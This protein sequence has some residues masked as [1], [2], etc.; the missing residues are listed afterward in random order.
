MHRVAELRAEAL[1]RHAAIN[2]QIAIQPGR[3][4]G[5]HLALD[6]QVR[7]QYKSGARRPLRIVLLRFL[8]QV[9]RDLPNAIGHALHHASAS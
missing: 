4:D 9:V 5:A 6:R 7:A 8:T 1:V 3:A 2:Y